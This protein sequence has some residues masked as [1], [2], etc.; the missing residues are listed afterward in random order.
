MNHD[1]LS[2]IVL[3]LVIY[4]VVLF[5]VFAATIAKMPKN[6]PRFLDF[7]AA[8]FVSLVWPVALVVQP[9]SWLWKRMNR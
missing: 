3:A 1:H 9:F 8:I 2:P 5:P 7:L 4:V 6:D